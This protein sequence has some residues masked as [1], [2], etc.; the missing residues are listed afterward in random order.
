MLGTYDRSR[1]NTHQTKQNLAAA[2]GQ[3]TNNE[4]VEFKVQALG[5]VL[6]FLLVSI[7]SVNI[8][9]LSFMALMPEQI[10]P[11]LGQPPS[12]HLTS[13]ALSVYFVSMVVISCHGI[14]EGTKP[15]PSWIHF[16]YRCMFYFLYFTADALPENLLAVLV[17]GLILSLL[18]Y[19]G[20]RSY[21]AK[22]ESNTET[23]G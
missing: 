23:A 2:K 11:F 3:K 14:C 10:R 22:L 1:K 4:G 12:A 21:L 13:I 17:S 20:G 16:G 18:E 5:P 6:A 9:D 7:L 19:L 8:Q 15:N